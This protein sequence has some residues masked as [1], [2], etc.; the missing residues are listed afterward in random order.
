MANYGPDRRSD[1]I[2]GS[3]QGVS[4]GDNRF[5]SQI[6]LNSKVTPNAALDAPSYGKGASPTVNLVPFVL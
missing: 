4:D 1:S 2:A 6:Q 5:Q 3:L